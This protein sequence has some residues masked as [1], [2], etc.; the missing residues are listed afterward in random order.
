[1]KEFTR[2]TLYNYLLLEQ[3]RIRASL[4]ESEDRPETEVLRGQWAIA[5]RIIGEFGLRSE[6]EWMH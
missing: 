3:G 4:E 5:Q 6:Y 1:M 2:T